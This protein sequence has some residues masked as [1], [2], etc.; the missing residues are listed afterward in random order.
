MSRTLTTSTTSSTATRRNKAAPSTTPPGEPRR[1][2]YL[3]LLPA[4]LVYGVFLLFPLLHSGWLSLYEWDGLSVGTWAGLD[5]YVGIFTEEGALASFGHVGVL[6]VF[7]AVI[8]VC[9]GLVLA[10][11]LHRIRVR[12][13]PFFRT[14]LFLPQ[15]IA[16]VVVAVAWQQIYAPDGALN[17]ALRFIGLDGI[18][19]TWLG[20]SGT[21][22]FAVGAVGTWVQTGLVVVLMLGGIG[23][24]SDELFDAARLDGAGVVWEFRAVILPALRKEIGVALTL[25]VIAALRT[26]DLVYMM[27]PQG[28]PGG[29]TTVP[30]YEVYYQAFRAGE[31]GSAAAIGVVI[32]LLAFGI[33]FLITRITGRER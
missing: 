32:T 18:T 2:G 25:T 15:V 26:F 23:K 13:L 7:F 21:A 20:D 4:L 24:I 22:L 33:T 14:S 6:V 17:E 29:S 27:T 28:G 8:P 31:V 30:S 5:N 3:Y 11:A 1:V 12:G 10:T 16:M 19:R 9:I